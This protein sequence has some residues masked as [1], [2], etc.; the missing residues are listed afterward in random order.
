MA[1]TA[2]IIFGIFSFPDYDESLVS[3]VTYCANFD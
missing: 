2:L 1:K 3:I